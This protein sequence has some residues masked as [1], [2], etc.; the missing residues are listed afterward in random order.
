MALAPLVTI[1]GKSVPSE[2]ETELC[3]WTSDGATGIAFWNGLGSY[4]ARFRFYLN[5]VYHSG[6]MTDETDRTAYIPLS[7]G[8][9]PSGQKAKLTVYHEAGSSQLF[10]GSIC[11]A[12]S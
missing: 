5:N 2:V 1:I 7:P 10:D 8:V 6:F 3:S 9:I 4:P 11:P 12:G